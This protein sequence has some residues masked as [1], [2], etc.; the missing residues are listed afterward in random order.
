MAH[1][2]SAEKKRFVVYYIE[3]GEQDKVTYD[4]SN[5]RQALADSDIGNLLNEQVQA[6]FL[7]TTSGFFF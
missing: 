3:D 1:S 5:F 2:L 7:F 6:N 4:T